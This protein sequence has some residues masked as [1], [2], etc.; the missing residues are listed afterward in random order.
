[1][2]SKGAKRIIPLP[3]SGAFH[4][5]LM[6]S[7]KPKLK[8]IISNETFD[9]PIIPIVS[10]YDGKLRSNPEEIKHALIE[11]IDSPVLWL[12]SIKELSKISKTFTEIGPKK[13]LS[14]IIKKID[15]L[16]HI[17]SFNNYN[18][19]QEKINV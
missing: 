16:F 6:S 13:V 15:E 10:N 4:S 3:V 12:D 1:M 14:G 8:H 17:S 2:K 9:T 7:A 5:K 18:D 19:I 11:Q